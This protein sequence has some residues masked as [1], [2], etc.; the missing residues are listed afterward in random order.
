MIDAL[1][2]FPPYGAP[3]PERQRRLLAA[4]N[5]AYRHHTLNCPAY[6]RF[7]EKRGFDAGHVFTSLAEIPYLPVQAF[8]ENS[9]LLRSVAPDA[10]RTILQSS[11]TSGVPSTVA[12]DRVTAKR[13]VKALTAVIAASLGRQRRPF[14]VLDVAPHAGS[15]GLGARGAAVRGFLNLASEVRYLMHP[16]ADGTLALLEEEFAQAVA[17]LGNPAVVFGFTYVLY[18]YAIEPLWRANKRLA[19]PAGS[20]V[21]HIGGW[22]K[23]ADRSVPRGMFDDAV[24][25]T[26]G[27]PTGAIIDFYGFTEQMG[28]T[29]PTGP[30]GDKHCPAFAEVI[31]R[32]PATF[33]PLPDGQEG[34]L[35]FLTP[36]PHAYPG[37]AVL[38]DDVGV[39]TGRAN[40][41]EVWGGTRFCVL[42]RAKKA[43]VR[44]CGDIMGEKMMR[45]PSRAAAPVVDQSAEVRLLF[46]AH[47]NHVAGDLFM[48][49][50]TA[51]LPRIDDLAALAEH[52][53]QQRAALD[54]YSLDDLITLVSAAARRWA[55][56]S[57]PLAPLRQQ[58]LLFLSNWCR[59][60]TLRRL[61]DASLHGRR[62]HLDG[63][64]P[65][66]NSG[67]EFLRAFPRG[68]V[69]H[70]LAGNV[71]LLGMLVLV[72]SIVCRNANLLKAASSFSRVLPALL[73]AFRGL[74]VVTA[75]GASLSGDDVLK[76]LAVVYF[77]RHDQAAATQMS[78][79]ADVRLAW[80]GAEAVTGIVDLP[81]RFDAQDIIFGPKLSY[82]V[83]GR[84]ALARERQ[85]R[86]L[87]RMAATDASVFDQYACASPHT[88]FVERGGAAA[89]PRA[90]A[91][92]LAMEMAKAAIRIPKAPV[93][94]GGVTVIESARLRH[95]LI[96]DVWRS[97]DA[98]WTVLY[99]DDDAAGL[100]PPCYSRVIMVRATTDALACARHASSDI[101][102]IGLALPGR[103][104][105]VFAEQAA[106]RGAERF[107]DIGRMTHFQSPWDGSFVM[108]RMVGWVSLGG[109]L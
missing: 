23:L 9:D 52:L 96:G 63:F 5:V 12:V 70:W 82:M 49:V 64:L 50:Q 46:D 107:P 98:T 16:A 30:S 94:P 69:C 41:S 51:A 44:G 100:F 87:A 54:A 38:T 78:A 99:T 28:V 2:E 75:G 45:R 108:D 105:L 90:F 58:G 102:T 85:V 81:R 71:P 32:D 66:A 60:E 24:S 53:K 48:P 8:K 7:C 27:V 74:R 3:E 4:M 22:K 15:D 19:L 1:L 84:E 43:E 47:A 29:Y 106:L 91:A 55:D 37:I 34:L 36:L 72:Q 89:T 6:R 21:V 103:R 39:I 67:R 18:A 42:G 77:D 73:E 68:L 88:I 97:D 92:L 31:V 40:G 56:P 109:P 101:Q 25:R 61:A 80:G 17:D 11:A 33:E 93:D 76:T 26:L 35:E 65:T 79:A 104:R 62:G 14:L 13:Q 86:R 10:V 83:I 59:G 95:E 20:N 57:G